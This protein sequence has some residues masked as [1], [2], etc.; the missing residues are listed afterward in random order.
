MH[1]G[2]KVGA[3][4]V[5]VLCFSFSNGFLCIDRSAYILYFSKFSFFIP[6]S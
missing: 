5:I 2:E 3:D 4:C 1:G 6:T